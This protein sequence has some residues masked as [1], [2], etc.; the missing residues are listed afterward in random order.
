MLKRHLKLDRFRKLNCMTKTGIVIQARMGSTRRPGKVSYEILG[1]AMLVH[2]IKRLQSAGLEDIIIATTTNS[3]DDWVESCCQEMHILCFRGS[4]DDVLKRYLDCAIEYQLDYVVRVGGD[5]PLIDPQGIR[6]LI[7]KS[8]NYE[9]DFYYA[10]HPKGWIYGTAAEMVTMDAL[11]RMDQ[12]AKSALDR[13]H[14]VS[15]IRK[16]SEFTQLKVE[17]PQKIQRPDIY[18]SVDYQE[19]LDLVEQVLEHFHGLGKLHTFSQYELVELYDSGKLDI[20]NK[21]LHEGF[22]D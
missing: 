18:F 6:A 22:G 1:E 19:D 21:H 16:S 12:M 2:Q 10:S 5:D 11:K 8:K 4:E 14:V 13:E 9:A 7:E 17:T 20:Q 3:N 15:Y